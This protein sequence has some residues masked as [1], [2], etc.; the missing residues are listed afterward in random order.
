M[1]K[2]E[3]ELTEEQLKKVEILQNNNIDVGSAIDMLFEIKEESYKKEAAY[4]N[5]KLDQANKQRK[6][7]EEKLNEVNKEISLYSQLKDSSLDVDQKRK[8]LEKDYGEVDASYEM[9]VQDVKHN[10]NWTRK[11]FKF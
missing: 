8:I 4:L 11:F 7:L 2:M 9:K 5:N 6:E 10:I 1:A 3:I